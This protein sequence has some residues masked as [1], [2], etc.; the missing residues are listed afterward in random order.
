MPALEGAGYLI[1]YLYAVGPTMGGGPIT[2][3]E[4]RA[5]MDLNG[6]ELQPWEVRFLRRL[7]NEYLIESHRATKR[8]CAPPWPDVVIKPDVYDTRAAI[9]ALAGL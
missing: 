8:D 6:V 2:H 5:W 9:R 3:G 1:G 4:L 7:S